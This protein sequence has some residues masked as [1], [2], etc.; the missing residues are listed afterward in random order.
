MSQGTEEEK[1]NEDGLSF[2]TEHGCQMRTTR[3]LKSSKQLHFIPIEALGTLAIDLRG[4]NYDSPFALTVGSMVTDTRVCDLRFLTLGTMVVSAIVVDSHILGFDMY[5]NLEEEG[6][7]IKGKLT[8]PKFQ[9]QKSFYRKVDAQGCVNFGELLKDHS[10][11]GLKGC[12][13]VSLDTQIFIQERLYFWAREIKVSSSIQ[14]QCQV[15][16]ILQNARILNQRGNIDVDIHGHW[17]FNNKRMIQAVVIKRAARGLIPLLRSVELDISY[18]V[19]LSEEFSLRYA[20][21]VGKAWLELIICGG[22]LLLFLSKVRLIMIH[23]FVG[24]MT[25][26]TIMLLNILIF[27]VTNFSYTKIGWIEH[28]VV[29]TVIGKSVED[30]LAKTG[31]S[32]IG[33][34]LIDASLGEIMITCEKITWLLA[35]VEHWL[36]PEYRSSRRFS[37]TAEVVVSSVDKTIFIGSTTIVVRASLQSSKQ[38]CVCAEQ[39]YV[40]RDFYPFFVAQVTKIATSVCVGSPLDGKY[41]MGAICL[42]KPLE[43]LV[44]ENDFALQGFLGKHYMT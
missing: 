16:L 39:F 38:N 3:R 19:A 2:Q 1:T 36:K 11:I 30:Y 27:S 34:T 44:A 8:G 4:A 24:V 7:R 22:L 18:L 23:Y 9:D 37:E 25:W 14:E 29:S 43:Y 28:N 12:F 26:T 42:Q 6:Q 17:N 15:G 33:K 41:D 5:R 20:I 32:D 10:C 31:T 21:D 13:V 40:H 35:K